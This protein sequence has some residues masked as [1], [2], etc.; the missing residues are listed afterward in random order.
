MFTGIITAVGKISHVQPLEKGLRLTV[1]AP[2]SSSEMS[3]WEIRSR[4]AA[5]ASP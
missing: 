5:S 3:R 1:E 2:A 4:T